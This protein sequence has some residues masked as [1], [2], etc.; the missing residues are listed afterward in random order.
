MSFFVANPDDPTDGRSIIL[1]R[2]RK[3]ENLL[4]EW[5]RGVKVFDEGS[6]D[7]EE[8]A[9]NFLERIRL[10]TSTAEIWSKHQ[11]HELDLRNVERSQLAAAKKLL[12][13]MN[14]DKRFKLE[15]D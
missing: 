8:R 7:D 6:E 3:W 11:R 5:E 10:G 12:K 4:P 14:Y 13:K 9:D 2:D 15:V 1:L